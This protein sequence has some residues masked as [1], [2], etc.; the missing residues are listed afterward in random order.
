MVILGV[1]VDMVS[2]TRLRRIVARS[3]RF[4]RR[5]YHE[6]ELTQTANRPERLA[7]RFAAKEA[8]LKAM[9]LP[10]FSTP[11]TDIRVQLDPS[12]KPNLVLT[13]AAL[14]LSRKR[15]VTRCHVSL[16]HTDTDAIAVVVLEGEGS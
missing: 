3:P 13:G 9:G 6:N 5:V 8:W 10:L 16:S 7:A 15:G 12:G 4:C 11:L 14:A 1:G 2:V